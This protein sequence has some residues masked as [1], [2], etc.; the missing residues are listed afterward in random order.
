MST[1][2]GAEGSSSGAGSKRNRSEQEAVAQPRAPKRPKSATT[3]TAKKRQEQ[4]GAQQHRMKK[5]TVPAGARSFMRALYI[6][7]RILWGVLSS[8]DVPELPDESMIAVFNQRYSSFDD[9][10]A[11]RSTP[12]TRIDN[13]GMISKVN[14]LRGLA[15]G[16]ST[17]AK[18]AARVSDAALKYILASLARFGLKAWRPNFNEDA[19]S[20]YN[21]AH[22]FIAI[23][24][25]RQAVVSNAYDSM[26]VDKS[27]LDD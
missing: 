10:V 9:V 2:T 4:A 27:Y 17:T 18:Q 25:F 23:D 24:T 11:A 22:R 15:G 6:H 8:T 21:S 1:T 20:L 26:A 16:N 7:I 3:P 5:I 12:N 13:N 14:E 19:Y